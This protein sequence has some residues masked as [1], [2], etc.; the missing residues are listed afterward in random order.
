VVVNCSNKPEDIRYI[1]NLVVDIMRRPFKGY[2]EQDI[3]FPVNVSV[4][5]RWK[6]WKFLKVYK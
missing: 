6:K 2:I 1:I 4:G 5:N 3:V